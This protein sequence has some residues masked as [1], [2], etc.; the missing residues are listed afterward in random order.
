MIHCSGIRQWLVS[1][2]LKLSSLHSVCTYMRYISVSR[3]G[4][5]F[6]FVLFLP[7]H[8]LAVHCLSMPHVFSSFIS[9]AG[10]HS[11]TRQAA[12]SP[13]GQE[14]LGQTVL[15]ADLATQYTAGVWRCGLV[16]VASGNCCWRNNRGICSD[17]LKVSTVV[18]VSQGLF[19]VLT[20]PCTP[21]I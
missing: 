10:V 9:S 21:K 18:R 14:F 5:L 16:H 11:H 8:N 20:T 4:R 19:S 17:F 1:D 15:P 13:R 3:R 12:E 7:L 6:S 2:I